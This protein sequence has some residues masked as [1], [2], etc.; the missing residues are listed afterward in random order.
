MKDKIL[1]LKKP[2][3]LGDKNRQL[4]SKGG[5]GEISCSYAFLGISEA[6]R[7]GGCPN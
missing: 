2:R 1:C 3:T 7:P 6:G 4:S 5:G